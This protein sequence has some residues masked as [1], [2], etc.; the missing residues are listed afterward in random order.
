M[1]RE[2]DKNVTDQHFEQAEIEK[3]PVKWL[4]LDTEKDSS[5][6]TMQIPFAN[7]EWKSILPAIRDRNMILP[8]SR[9]EVGRKSNLSFKVGSGVEGHLC[10][11]NSSEILEILTGL[12]NDAYNRIKNDVGK[13]PL[14][15]FLDDPSKPIGLEFLRSARC[16]FQIALAE[17]RAMREMIERGGYYY[18]GNESKTVS[19]SRRE[20]SLQYQH[21]IY[22]TPPVVDW[23][24][25]PQEKGSLEFKQ[26]IQKSS[27]PTCPIPQEF[28]GVD[29]SR[30][31][32]NKFKLL[33][34]IGRFGHPI[35]P[36]IL[37]HS[38]T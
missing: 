13:L 4:V 2:K 8:C 33:A 3:Y 15:A 19:P 32:K 30:Y 35:V 9:W 28:I 36:I 6:F 18:S 7:S 5:P 25:L 24:V 38:I 22:N 29:I 23:A 26:T 34:E 10:A 27:I 17:A 20:R 1:T 14:T 31:E 21:F 11:F 37:R 16:A 12:Q